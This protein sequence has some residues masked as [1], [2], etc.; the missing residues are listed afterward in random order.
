[1]TTESSPPPDSDDLIQA[2]MLNEYC[3]C[4]RLFHLMRVEGRWADNEY[5][6]DGQAVHRTVDRVEGL[7]PLR[8]SYDG[9]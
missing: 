4:P 2:R 9:D 6:V 1:M 5:T 8:D 7:L 3:Y